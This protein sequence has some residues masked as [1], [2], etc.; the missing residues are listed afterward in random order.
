MRTSRSPVAARYGPAMSAPA[1]APEHLR[2]TRTGAVETITID[3][4]ER[5]N[6]TS[7]GTGQ[8]LLAAIRAA[9]DDPAVRVIVLTGAGR[10]FSAGADL[11]AMDGP[12]LPDGRPDLA[13]IL[14]GTFNP[15]VLAIRAAPKPVIAAVG[16]RPSAS[17]APWR[18][19]ATH[20]RQPVRAAHRGFSNVGLSLDGGLSLLLARRAGATRAAEAALVGTPIDGEQ[21]MAWGLANALVEDDE[22]R[23]ATAALAERL[24]RSAGG[25]GG[26]QAALGEVVDAG[27]AEALEREAVS[28]GERSRSAEFVEGVSAFLERRAPDFG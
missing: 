10:A 24:A 18:S 12:A 25:A 13:E 3:R 7:T 1:A 14:R 27:L 8:A 26:E 23:S 28:Q 22:L 4:P 19:R 6:A 9:G 5:M 11:R 20:D 21:A 2:V 15:L 17:A 16:G